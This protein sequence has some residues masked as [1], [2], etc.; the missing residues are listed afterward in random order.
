[1]ILQYTTVHYTT[2]IKPHQ[3]YNCTAT[4]AT[5]HYNY[6]STTLQLQLQLHYT[7]LHAAVVGEVASATIATILKNTA[8]TTFRS[9]SVF[10]L[11]PM[12]RNN[13]P[14][15]WRPIFETSATALCGT[16]GLLQWH[17]M[18]ILV[19]VSAF[20]SPRWV[21]DQCVFSPKSTG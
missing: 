17:I 19:V 6:N 5:L 13:S 9:I 2:L 8:P 11:P 20:G 7:T 3:N 15:L 10:A 21:W 4:T 14:L 18:E 16:A 12:H 1:M